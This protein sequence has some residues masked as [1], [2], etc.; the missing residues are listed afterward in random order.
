[1]DD[2]LKELRRRIW[3]KKQ[4]GLR[5]ERERDGRLAMGRGDLARIGKTGRLRRQISTLA[6]MNAVD[7]EGREVLSKAGENYWK[8][9][10]RREFGIN[11]DAVRSTRALRNRHGRVSFRKVY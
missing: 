5:R 6:V 10:D 1:M 11:E 4:E 7:T 2:V 9:Q 3:E 8:D